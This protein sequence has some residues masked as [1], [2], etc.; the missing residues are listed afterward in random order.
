MGVDERKRLGYVP[1]VVPA[2]REDQQVEVTD[3]GYTPPNT[4]AWTL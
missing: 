4:A 2:E 3:A 1:L